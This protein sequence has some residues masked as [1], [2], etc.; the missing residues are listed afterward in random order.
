MGRNL[1][2]NKMIVYQ[3]K[4]TKSP[5]YSCHGFAQPQYPSCADSCQPINEYLVHIGDKPIEKPKMD[6]KLIPFTKGKCNSYECCSAEQCEK[7]RKFFHAYRKKTGANWKQIS[8]L[9]G[10]SDALVSSIQRGN[11][12]R[13]AMESYNKIAAWMEKEKNNG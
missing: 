8:E 12:K 4:A 1:E 13:I 6:L 5:C 10:V 2:R 9:I 11:Q 7:V 3:F